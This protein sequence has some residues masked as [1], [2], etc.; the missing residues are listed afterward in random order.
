M[1]FGDNGKEYIIGT[2]NICITPSTYIEIV[3]LVDGLKHNLLCISKL[4]DKGI[5]V[6]FESLMFIMSRPLKIMVSFLLDIDM[7]MSA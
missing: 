4:C 2:G 6:V 7:R 1:T 5:K 3:L